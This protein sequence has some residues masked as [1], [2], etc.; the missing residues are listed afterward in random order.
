MLAHYKAAVT[1]LVSEKATLGEAH[2]GINASR[3]AQ[4]KH[5]LESLPTYPR[6]MAESAH[7]LE[8]LNDPT[9]DIW[10]TEQCTTMASAVSVHMRAIDSRSTTAG[11]DTTRQNHPWLHEWLSAPLWDALWNGESTEDLFETQSFNAV[12]RSFSTAEAGRFRAGIAHTS[13]SIENA[14]RC[15]IAPEVRSS[16]VSQRC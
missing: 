6:D 5:F 15:I 2:A 3:T 8:L 7:V 10:A 13:M 1:F 12:S 4:M 11:A 16:S 14:T 9:Q